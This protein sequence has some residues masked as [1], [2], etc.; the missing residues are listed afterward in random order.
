M[1]PRISDWMS[2]LCER[3]SALGHR[4][5]AKFST[6]HRSTY[7]HIDAGPA[8]TPFDASRRMERIVYGK[9]NP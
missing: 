2:H 6:R 9:E 7:W 8:L 1:K 4:V 3:M 5:E